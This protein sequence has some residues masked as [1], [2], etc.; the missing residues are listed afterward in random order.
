MTSKLGLSDWAN[1][2][3]IIGGIAIIASLIFVGLELRQTT[4]QMRLSSDIG[5]DASNISLSVRIAENAELSDIVFRGENDP[6]SLT[7]FEMARFENVALPRIAM[8]ENTFDL[9]EAGNMSETDWKSWDEFNRL[10]WQK[11]GYKVVY[12]KFRAGFGKRSAPYFEAL[13]DLP[14]LE[15][16]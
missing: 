4:A 6:G 12:E 3:E 2:A 5:A 8:W 13:F 14:P 1:I 7:D 10:R 15:R 9:Y 16:D 11:P